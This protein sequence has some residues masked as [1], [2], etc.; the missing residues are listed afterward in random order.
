MRNRTDG[1]VIR[2]PMEMEDYLE[3]NNL[4][5]PLLKSTET[6]LQELQNQALDSEILMDEQRAI[7][8]D[9]AIQ[10]QVDLAL[11]LY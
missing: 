11:R 3:Q 8:A 2:E 4:D 9:L 5:S 1:I 7:E 10:N 6:V